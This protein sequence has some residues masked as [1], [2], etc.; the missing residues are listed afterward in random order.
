MA[1]AIKDT[2]QSAPFEGRVFSLSL[3]GNIGAPLVATLNIIGLNVQIPVWLQT[4]LNVSN[5]LNS[6]QISTLFHEHCMD[7]DP[8]SSASTKSTPSPSPS[9]SFGESLATTNQ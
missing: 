2:N 3:F 4:T 1:K 9:S 8:L 6:S 7:V 5:D